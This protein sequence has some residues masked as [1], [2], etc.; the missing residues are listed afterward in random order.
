TGTRLEPECMPAVTLRP[1]LHSW[2][3]IVFTNRKG[4]VRG[5]IEGDA[6]DYG[7]R[8]V[9]IPV[10]FEPSADRVVA[11]HR[12]DDVEVRVEY[13]WQP[14][15]DALVSAITLRNTGTGDVVDPIVTTEWQLP[16]STGSTWP[17]EF[18]GELP[19]PPADVHRLGLMPNNLRPGDD[20]ESGF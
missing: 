12:L 16:G 14:K 10:S 6:P 8:Q 11:V 5:V 1:K 20:Q 13:W 18:S 19:P 3:G 2:I 9:A 7:G 4:R 15:A 17:P